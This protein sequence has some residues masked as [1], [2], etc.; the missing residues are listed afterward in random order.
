MTRSAAWSWRRAPFLCGY[1]INTFNYQYCHLHN[2]IVQLATR[3][4]WSCH[5]VSQYRGTG[6]IPGRMLALSE[7]GEQLPRTNVGAAC[8]GAT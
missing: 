2:G 7:G 6:G 4:E 1:L 3:S 8:L 5:M